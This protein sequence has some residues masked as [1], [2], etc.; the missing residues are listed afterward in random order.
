M[1]Q[2]KPLSLSDYEGLLCTPRHIGVRYGGLAND[3]DAMLY[4]REL[5]AVCEEINK[6]RMG[7]VDVSAEEAR[8]LVAKNERIPFA[9]KCLKG[10]AEDA[11]VWFTE[12]TY[13]TR[14]LDVE[15]FS[16]VEIAGRR[17]VVKP[18]CVRMDDEGRLHVD[19]YKTGWIPEQEACRR[20]PR[21]IVYAFAVAKFYG[22]QTVVTNIWNI[23]NQFCITIE[24][25]PEELARVEQYIEPAAKQIIKIHEAVQNAHD[26]LA[27]AKETPPH[28]NDW[29][30]S[31]PGALKT[32]CP[33]HRALILDGT[34]PP[35]VGV[36]ARAQQ[37]GTVE[38]IVT[39]E[40]RKL[41]AQAEAMVLESG[42]WGVVTQKNGEERQIISLKDGGYE[43]LVK[44]E[45]HKVG[46]TDKAALA[47]D[48]FTKGH[49]EVVEVRKKTYAQY[50]YEL[51]TGL[52]ATMRVAVDKEKEI[53]ANAEERIVKKL[54]IYKEGVNE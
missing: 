54:V 34:F 11:A 16:E 44:V 30:P 22:V 38:R 20:N 28:L 21:Y 45:H 52:T 31:C 7:G 42:V 18:D 37:L 53:K 13:G 50:T 9:R 35:E 32:G 12:R 4:G 23:S 49:R 47:K 27:L 51:E 1:P 8:A 39:A 48:C 14:P 5:H 10:G 24:W 43:A 6:L 3:S 25:K 36:I 26:P 19:D 2:F 15:S 17:W 29:C 41:N 46:E 33:L 40:R